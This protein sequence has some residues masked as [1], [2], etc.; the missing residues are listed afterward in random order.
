MVVVWTFRVGAEVYA[1]DSVVAMV[2]TRS[3]SHPLP[4]ALAVVD[5][6]AAVPMSGRGDA[7]VGSYAHTTRAYCKK[8]LAG[9]LKVVIVV[10]RIHCCECLLYTNIPLLG[11]AILSALLVIVVPAASS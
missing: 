1:V 9:L 10:Y 2:T 7:T 6:D 3:P 11:T 4:C 5:A 8:Q